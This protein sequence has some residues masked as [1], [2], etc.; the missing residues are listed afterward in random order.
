ME[1]SQS[2]Q[3]KVFSEILG[4]VEMGD[5]FRLASVL[6]LIYPRAGEPYVVFM[7]RTDTV[8]HHKGQISLPGGGRDA[9]DPDVV[10]TALREAEEELGIDPAI[11][12][13]IGTLPD[14][15]AHV[16]N[17]LITP[18]VALLKPD[19][20]DRLVFKPAPEEVAEVIEVPL[21]VF[22]DE[23]VH[24][25]EIRAYNNDTYEVHYYTYGP[26]E[27]WGVTG[28]IMYEFTHNYEQSAF[29]TNN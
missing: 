1:N 10:Y 21:R 12:E 16:S 8:E 24:R 7:R 28:R 26:Y 19:A 23:S 17:F 3:S 2:A 20:E 5:Q 13:V 4:P 25:V 29:T 27:V 14:F 22:Y 15:Y 6:I 9:T 18:V 11:V